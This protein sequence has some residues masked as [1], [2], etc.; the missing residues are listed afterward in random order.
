MQ[1][2][3]TK[4]LNKAPLPKSAQRSSSQTNKQVTFAEVPY[5]RPV[6]EYIHKQ[7]Q[8]EESPCSV[9]EKSLI[10][11]ND[12]LATLESNIQQDTGRIAS[13]PEF[14]KPDK[15]TALVLGFKVR[16]ILNGFGNVKR[17]KREYNDLLKFAFTL[18]HELNQKYKFNQSVKLMLI[19]TVKDLNNKRLQFN[20]EFWHVYHST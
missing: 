18:Q 9:I 20:N 14:S 1:R 7:V 5:T 19:Q 12:K 13:V 17:L 3:S 6:H 16:H 15:L 2:S 11:D 10:F 4:D 8:R